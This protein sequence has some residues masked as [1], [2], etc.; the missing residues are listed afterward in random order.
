MH[1]NPWHDGPIGELVASP[2]A[3]R[4]SGILT[5]P[6]RAQFIDCLVDAVERNSN[7]GDRILAYYD[8]PWVYGLTNRLPSTHKTWIASWTSESTQQSALN[9][10][11]D[12]DRLPQLV[13]HCPNVT[14]ED[15]TPT[16]TNSPIIQYVKEHY[17]VIEVCGDCD[18]M[19]PVPVLNLGED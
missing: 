9:K 18:I 6:E 16:A 11:I 14:W 1:S 7:V 3:T 15:K 19:L 10:M 5:T 12:R 4:A 17:E 13:A 2:I 8:V